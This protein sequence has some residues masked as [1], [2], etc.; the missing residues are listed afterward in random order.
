MLEA[1]NRYA[2][3]YVTVPVVVACRKRGLFELLRARG[4]AAV[5]D[6]VKELGA[7]EGHLRAALRLLQ[8]LG[9]L[10]EVDGR[11]ALGD[12]A[13]N[14]REVPEYAVEALQLPLEST[15]RGEGARER[16][17]PWIERVRR[18]WGTRN[19]RVADLLDGTLVVRVLTA[20]ERT[21]A[22][23]GGPDEV[24]AR[25]PSPSRGELEGL[26]V[27]LGWAG[28]EGEAFVLTDVGRFI[29]DRALILG[30]L[31]AYTPML[32]R[33]PTLLFGDAAKVFDR[34]EAGQER[35]VDRTLNVASSGFQHDRYFADVDEMLIAIFD[36][37][38]LSEQPR[39][40]A[41]MGCG[42]GTFLR[43]VYETVRARTGRGKALGEHPLTLIGID[44]NEAALAATRRTLDG[45]PHVLLQGDIGDPAAL[46]ASF[47]ESGV[48][49]EAV[50]H[51][52]SFLDHDRPFVPGDGERA[53]RRGRFGHRGVYVDS[54]GASIPPPV[55]IQALVEHLGR[56]AAVVNRHGLVVLEVH[57]LD[58]HV[59]NAYFDSTESIHFDAYHAFS[60]Q[61][62][63][64]AAE[65]V[66]A[67]AEVGLFPRAGCS[68]R[69]P[70]TL[71][72]ARI[73]LNWLER[74]PY[75]IR[76]AESDDVPGLVELE[77]VA[78]SGP[79]RA[80][81]E[82]LQARIEGDPSGQF[83]VER[84]GRVAAAAYSQRI[85]DVPR[86]QSARHAD[87]ASLRQPSGPVIQLLG[88]V[89]DPEFQDLGLGDD[90]LEFVLQ[91][92]ELLPGVER[93]AGISRC[94]EW[95]KEGGV[96]FAEYVHARTAGG[97]PQ[98]PILRFHARH[99]ARVVGVVSG[100]RPVDVENDGGGVVIE[101]D[102]A[103]RRAGARTGESRAS[104]L[105]EGR[106]AQVVEASV[107][108][109]LGPRR[110]PAFA[111]GMPLMDMGLDSMDLTELKTLL[112]R[113][114]GRELDATLF[115]RHRTPAAVAEHLGT[116]EGAA[117]GPL[118]RGEPAAPQTA[119]ARPGGLR[120]ART[121]RP[122]TARTV[123]PSRPA[124]A[125]DSIAI[126]G[127]ACR[128]ASANDVDEYWALLSDGVNAIREA[129]PQRKGWT[130][131]PISDADPAVASAI[132]YG[133]FLD[134]V[135]GF[136]AAFFGISPREARSMDPQQRIL[137]ETSW[138]AF[139]HAG[140]DATSL[141]SSPTGVFVGICTHDYEVLQL[142][143]RS[144]Q[145]FD[146][147][148]TSGNL[149]SV[150]AGRLAYCYGFHGPALSVDTACSSS[151]VALH[152]ASQSLRAGE[153]DV[154]LACGVNLMLAREMSLVYARLRVLAP[155]GR[156]KTF[157]AAADGY[158]R[159]EGCGVVVL[160]RLE[161]AEADGDRILA[162]VRGSAINQDGPSN[163]LTA[164]NGDAQEA[165]IRKALAVA[166]VSPLDVSHVEAH[167]TG[168]LIGDPIEVQALGRVFGPGRTADRPLI[169]TSAKTAVGH[170]EPAAGIAGLIKVVLSLQND[171][172]PPHQHLS[173]PNPLVPLEAIPAV[174]P[175]EGRPWT[176]SAAGPRRAG[177]SSFG[178]SGTNAHVIVEEAPPEASPEDRRA[179]PLHVLPLSAR[180]PTAL[181]TLARAYEARLRSRTPLRLADA[182][183]TAAVGRPHLE[184][185]L[186]VVFEQREELVEE[187]GRF[188]SSDATEPGRA[189]TS[190]GV[191]GDQGLRTA[192]L[193]SGQGAQYPGM[194]GELFDGEPVFREII[195]HC[196][197]VLR[198]DCGVPLVAVLYPRGNPP[199]L[200]ET[201]R[202]QPALF[203]VEY[204]LARLWQSWGVEPEAVIGHSL[205]EFTAACVAGVLKLD[206]ALRLVAARGRLMGSLE[207]AGAMVAA[208]TTAT[209][210]AAVIAGHEHEI[211]IAC[212]NGPGAVVLSGRASAVAAAA[213][214]LESE[215][216]R[217][218]ALAVSHAFHS[219]LMEP[220]LD[221][222]EA[223]ASRVELR[224]PDR[225]FVSNLLGRP[226]T[227]EV[228]TPGYWRRHLRE[229]VR[230]GEGVQS[231]LQVGIE[232]FLE[233]GPGATLLGLGRQQPE[234]APRTWL[235][236]MRRDAPESETLLGSLAGMYARGAGVDWA[237]FH[238]G[239][240]GRRVALPGYPFERKSYW[241]E[242]G[243]PREA[244]RESA[245]PGDTVREFYDAFSEV[246]SAPDLRYLTF[247]P[248][249]EP[250]PGFSW[251]EAFA[252]PEAHP[253]Q[254]RLFAEAQAEI[255]ST[256]FRHVDFDRS[257]RVLDFGCGYGSDLIDLARKHPHLQLCGYSLSDK[258]VELASRRARE[259]GVQERVTFEKKD[260]AR[261]AFPS[262]NDVV[263]GF[264]VAHHV[265]DKAA[266]FANVG[267]HLKEGGHLLLADFV[268]TTAFPIE[269]PGT[270][271]FFATRGEWEE[272]LTA[273]RLLVTECVDISREV[274][275][276][277]Y[278]PRFEEHLAAVLR[279][280]ETPSVEPAFRSFD[281][282]G[283]LLSKKLA[284]YVLIAARRLGDLP[285]EEV[286]RRNRD[287]LAQPRSYA[288]VS[289]AGA[290][291]EVEWRKVERPVRTTSAAGTR[292][293]WLIFADAEGVGKSLRERIEAEGG[294]CLTV[295]PGARFERITSGW[296]VDPAS[297]E[298]A[299]RLY[300]EASADG[301]LT[302]IV[303][304][305]SLA[306][307]RDE[308]PDVEAIRRQQRLGVESVLH[309]VQSVAASPEPTKPRLWLVTRGAQ[310]AGSE[311]R[312][313]AVAH[314]AVGGLARSLA[315]EMPELWGGM[316]DLPFGPRPHS[317]AEAVAGELSHAEGEL[318]VAYRGEGRFVARLVRR[319]LPPPVD[320]EIDGAGA[321]LVVGGLGALGQRVAQWL[322]D[323]GARYI[324]LAGR[325]GPNERSRE[326]I[327]K[328]R[329]QG[330]QV[331]VV[332]ADVSKPE[333]VARLLRDVASSLPG[334]KGIVNAAGVLDDGVLTSLDAERLR[335]VM[336]PKVDGSWNLHEQTRHVPLDFFVLFSSSVSLLS[337]AGRGAYGAANAF[338]DSLA[339]NR[340]AQGLP[341]V[342]VSWGAWAGPGM[343]ANL[344]D[345]QRRQLAARGMGEIEPKAALACLAAL[346][347]EGV[348]HAGVMP[349]DWAKYFR[350]VKPR[351]RSPFFEEVARSQADDSA[352]SDGRTSV[353]ARI[354]EAPAA[355]HRER[356]SRYLRQEVA[357]VL[358]TRVPGGVDPGQGFWAMGMDSLLALELRN[359]LQRGLECQLPATITM[360]CPN[361]N[362]LVD[363]LERELGMVD[364]RALAAKAT[365][366]EVTSPVG[367]QARIEDLT[368]GEAEALLQSRLDEMEY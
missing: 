179:R 104:A 106:V 228:T 130:R 148:F 314:A 64:E 53:R 205:G 196:D 71:P 338:L 281:Q 276:S 185:R 89:V 278:D 365:V 202:L 180:T 11:V 241:F 149:A 164:P 129:P 133:G 42:D 331:L 150:A 160:K 176:R 323:A 110:Q 95:A 87:L 318:G 232:A 349:V 240:G 203:S 174:V 28:R 287:A 181:R 220:I 10:V 184:H 136:D 223:E 256:V 159:G 216:V 31:A 255:R 346:M 67:A 98:D 329:E 301:P 208:A 291:Y 153:C 254:F 51:I 81:V 12:D 199:D 363:H 183:F 244:A 27:A 93:V 337:L 175:R 155:D 292:G 286:R 20:L 215:G 342:S 226:V 308:E 221:A 197:A 225:L 170:I 269:H 305:W 115:F 272:L 243:E 334:L 101:Y 58:S 137:L 165:V 36:R 302:G 92:A 127:M 248:F 322:V 69:Y 37:S 313:L 26:F 238:R 211:A 119:R 163:G 167:G 316:I 366:V 23:A 210:A 312:P 55:M 275:Y 299:R 41:D 62:L 154:A 249:P 3:G 151:L 74:R 111:P 340:R 356:L 103:D 147:H 310:P 259:E 325:R 343:A 328:L 284:L 99:G 15:F 212:L 354:R 295:A 189:R 5:S 80:T 257:S 348:P 17:G 297:G 265:R 273:N 332:E 251:V 186:A 188:A 230:F 195:E 279:G 139:E 61:Y 108:E 280:R 120:A 16:L 140:I 239:S 306:A 117:P 227:G 213:A 289:L 72:F 319:T 192:F 293:R 142:L 298:D 237:A 285:L 206:D 135:D 25:V 78:T 261:D 9:W 359:R 172:I 118:D 339:H 207:E 353:L 34:D 14:E 44:F 168:T 214:A 125:D 32:S 116:Q 274:A 358:G 22:L 231:L 335:K 326:G 88:L 68:R 364:S 8:S 132:R 235:P 94:K 260:S 29:L 224:P 112:A 131:L 264:E 77:R 246:Q 45:L 182:C 327:R 336:A 46:L 38:P 229:A 173:K 177:V 1:L 21:G 47:R 75:V 304:L 30:T 48:D 303:H 345:G 294:A 290:C 234:A 198:E 138:H 361:V 222:F 128:F 114:L 40:V 145:A 333:D 282:L 236:S 201:A 311:P 123:I 194:G 268:S 105:G 321:Y 122:A 43:R 107:R 152:L 24:L 258:Q 190:L 59:A 267:G 126:V 2:H 85:A 219:P 355:E 19:P 97:E 233:I 100:Y 33:M 341:A 102:L 49:P 191:A 166:G 347:A 86:L 161:H 134:Q 344:T 109:V 76:P 350:H 217:T 52:R 271:S 315:A 158:V 144:P 84:E 193:F 283:K 124:V 317:L 309:V 56:W 39:Y 6:L 73:T 50:L 60:M 368:E 96:P 204:A 247:A 169:I 18:R 66:T 121:V 330:A 4:P 83:V 157:D 288:E 242:E 357:E 266:L 253:E 270:S 263:F 91:R 320:L 35:H 187:L 252:F 277:L 113:R 141:A 262:D 218:K 178:L 360:D 13:E 296:R 307:D 324:A 250:V 367:A 54:H 171:R 362:A 90:L 63:V 65:F 7:N 82:E 146:S 156:C 300:A 351:L 352:D 143:T 70:K 162:V 245:A 200:K 57:N 209:R 79:L